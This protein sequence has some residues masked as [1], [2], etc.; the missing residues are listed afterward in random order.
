MKVKL[1]PAGTSGLGYEEGLKKCDELGLEA[2]ECEFTYGVRMS[3]AQAREVGKLAKELGVSLSVHAPYYINL[4]SKERVKVT[5]SKERILQ[6]C[7]RGHY[8]GAK[9]IVFHAGFYTGM[10]KELVYNNIKKEIVLLQKEIKKWDVVLAPETTGK[11]SQF[12]DLDELLRLRKETGCGI[13]VDFAHLK[14]RNVGKIDYD[15]VF[16]KLNV[17]GH[18]H[19]HFAGIEWTAKGERR[20]LLTE[21]K[22]IKELI[23]YIKKY[24]VDITI[25]NESPD[26]LGDSLKT[27]NVLEHLR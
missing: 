19:S 8:L 3:N 14:A 12:G 5:A 20:H 15:S 10:D 11:M 21:T 25:I 9:Y 4:N 13:C 18:V 7:E 2:L 22:D 16:K 23:G 24:K 6:S 26:P 17:L 1:G 27:K